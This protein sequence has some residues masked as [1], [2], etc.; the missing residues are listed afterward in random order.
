MLIKN[1]ACC[2][3]TQHIHA[4]PLLPAVACTWLSTLFCTTTFGTRS[5]RASGSLAVSPGGPGGARPRLCH[6]LAR[7]AGQLLADG[8]AG[9]GDGDVT[10]SGG[11]CF[12]SC[13]AGLVAGGLC[14]ITLSQ[15]GRPSGARSPASASHKR[16]AHPRWPS[17]PAPRCSPAR[18]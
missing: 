17:H 5:E 16:A 4:S 7:P 10:R 11:M 8:G 13:S 6:G 12:K 14:C 9:G 18:R 2:P 3:V 1:E 15:T